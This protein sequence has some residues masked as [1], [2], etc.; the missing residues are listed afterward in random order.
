MTTISP[1]V[2]HFNPNIGAGV[3][4]AGLVMKKVGAVGDAGKAMLAR[5][6]FQSQEIRRTING[7]R[8]VAGAVPSAY[9]TVRGAGNRYREGADL[10]SHEHVI[11]PPCQRLPRVQ[12]QA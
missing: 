6:E 8:S 10:F 7:I 3:A 4:S 9:T 11:Q 1:A 2:A 12:P 5:G